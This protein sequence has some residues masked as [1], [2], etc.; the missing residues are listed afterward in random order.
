VEATNES[1]LDFPQSCRSRPSPSES[2]SDIACQIEPMRIR[3]VSKTAPHY[4]N[5]IRTRPSYWSVLQFDSRLTG[6]AGFCY[7]VPG[8]GPGPLPMCSRPRACLKCVAR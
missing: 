6:V 2:K 3:L 5:S 4:K 8:G 1:D 7:Q